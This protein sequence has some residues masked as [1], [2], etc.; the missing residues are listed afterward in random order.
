[1]NYGTRSGIITN[2]FFDIKTVQESRRRIARYVRCKKKHVRSCL[3]SV[4]QYISLSP[5]S[6]FIH[7]NS[8]DDS[9]ISFHLIIRRANQ[10]IKSNI[11]CL[12]S[13]WNSPGFLKVATKT[14]RLGS[15]SELN[16]NKNPKK[17][18]CLSVRPLDTILKGYF[19]EATVLAWGD[20]VMRGKL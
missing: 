12:Q 10:F 9:G 8:K 3:V 14:C 13:W 5:R 2:N 20:H 17:K 6:S 16:W 11:L 15:W 4:N 1:M 7:F 19:Q 18:K